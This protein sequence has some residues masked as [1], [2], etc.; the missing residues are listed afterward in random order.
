[1]IKMIKQRR[2]SG[3]GRGA[4]SKKHTQPCWCGD[5]HRER[6][7]RGG[8]GTEKQGRGT[9]TRTRTKKE[10]DLGEKGGMS[11]IHFK[12]PMELLLRS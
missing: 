2:E 5:R 4:G 6:G 8:R 7:Q 9:A 11:L 3:L 12:F 1:M 10:G